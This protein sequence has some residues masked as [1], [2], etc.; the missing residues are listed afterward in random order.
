MRLIDLR[1]IIVTTSEESN[2]PVYAIKEQITG[3]NT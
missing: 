2:P 3:G 1:E